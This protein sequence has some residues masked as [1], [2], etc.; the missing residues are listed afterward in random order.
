MTTSGF[1]NL[2][3]NLLAWGLDLAGDIMGLIFFRS[4][5]LLAMVLMAGIPAG[6]APLVYLYGAKGIPLLSS[7]KITPAP[8][9]TRQN[10]QLKE[11]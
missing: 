6:L 7:R 2:V 1:L 9:K 10:S 11:E 8:V 4:N 5:F 3:F